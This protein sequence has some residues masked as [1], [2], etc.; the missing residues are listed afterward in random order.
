MEIIHIIKKN[1]NENEGLFNLKN[2]QADNN[3]IISP[4]SSMSNLF[5][6]LKHVLTLVNCLVRSLN[7]TLSCIFL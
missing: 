2:I 6:K 7:C 5:F 4:L 3:Q 1:G